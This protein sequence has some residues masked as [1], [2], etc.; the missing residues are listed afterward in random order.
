MKGM[1]YENPW[2]HVNGYESVISTWLGSGGIKA[3]IYGGQA[4]A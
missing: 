3:C 1:R 2:E 4:S